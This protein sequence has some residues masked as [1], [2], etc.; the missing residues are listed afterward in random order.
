MVWSCLGAAATEGGQATGRSEPEQEKTE[1]S[2][3]AQFLKNTRQL[4]FTGK[5]AGEGYF[6]PDGNHLIFQSEREPGN[7]FFQIYTLDFETGET[8]RVSPGTG[9]T[10]CAFFRPGTDEVLFAST[11][12]DPEAESKQK[13]EIEFRE[14]G[15][16]RRHAWDYD[17]HYDIFSSRRDGSDLKRLTEAFGYDAEGAYSPDGS[18]IVF[19]STRDA[20]PIEDLSAEDR[21]QMENDAAY[22]AEIYVMDADG[23]NQVRLTDW[24]GYDGGPFFT[25]DGKRIVWRHFDESGMLADVY[26]MRIDGSD[27]RRL[28]NFESMSWAPYFHPSGEYVIFTSNKFGFSNFELFMVDALGVKEPVRVTHTDG[29]DGLPV[30]SPDGKRLAWTS[31]RTAEKKSQIF[32]AEW[33]HDAALSALADAP[34]RP[35]SDEHRLSP[36][37]SAADLRAE[38]GFIA[39]DRLEGR[40][41]GSKG[42][43]LAAE[44]IGD[45]LEQAGI[46]PIGDGGTYFQEF[47]FTSG[48]KIVDKECAVELF[49]KG[50]GGEKTEFKVQKGF[51]PLA[52]SSSGEVEGNVVFAGYGLKVPGEG[53][54]GYDS[55]AGLDVKDKI[56]L[57]LRHVPEDVEMER[58][59]ELNHYAGLRYKAMVAR[60]NGAKA[61]LVVTG[62]NSHNAGELVPLKFDQSSQSSGI[63]AVSVNGDVADQLFAGSG[64]TLKDVQTGLDKENPHFEGAFDLPGVTVKLAASVERERS[65]D[66]NIIGVIPPAD[67][68]ED[69]EF[70]MIGAHYDHIG[71]G[72][73]GSLA[74]KD[75]RN[76]IHN[77]A[78]DNASG[79]SLVMEIAASLADERQGN[80][81]AFRRGLIV[82]L[83][84]GEEMGIIGSSYFAENPPVPLEKIVAYVNFDMVGRLRE[85]KLTLQGAGSSNTW[86]GLIE[87]RNVAAGFDLTI[88]KDPYLPTDA[89]AFYPRGVPVLS[90][91]TGVHDDYNKPTDDPETLEYDGMVRIAKLARSMIKDLIIVPERP[92]YVK[93]EKSKQQTGMSGEMRAYLGTVPDFASDDVEGVKL[94]G[95]RAGGPADKAGIQGG[96]I[97]VEF[98][99]QN[100]TNIYDY[101]FALRGVKIGEPVTIVVLRDGERV[102]FTV[103]PEARE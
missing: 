54:A 62:P 17:E 59:Q 61:I 66:Q 68:E 9:K 35:G 25:P 103:T 96:D 12:L 1:S 34:A 18:L 78:D 79:T 77:G 11:H 64:K 75:Q 14:S 57:V 29:F 49:K 33:N 89:S 15:Q 21:K 73:I 87:K 52:F 37:I 13:A 82:A 101:S 48:M 93:V 19:C 67:E 74:D 43:K 83:W 46:A 63:L 42:T 20:Y 6:S 85:N 69:A 5:R 53:A 90:F 24:P 81:Q 98:A 76:Q 10:T 97:I 102:T 95:V 92:D 32:I 27:R 38:V 41:T 28:T 40:M 36:E 22:F 45:Y 70:V 80:P 55:Y 51:R 91:F 16:K 31:N 72:D 8:H 65:S 4:I 50:D 26:T 30:F 2:G 47:P 23:K 71:H 88:Q 84:S 39:S 44:Y 100:I 56:V 94:S 58:R 86:S 60:E 7:P 3:E 99:G